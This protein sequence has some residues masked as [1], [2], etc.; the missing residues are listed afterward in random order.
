MGVRVGAVRTGMVPVRL[1]CDDGVM[2]PR[3]VSAGSPMSRC[4]VYLLRMTCCWPHGA[5]AAT[6]SCKLTPH[7]DHQDEWGNS[8]ETLD[9]IDESNMIG[10]IRIGTAT[11][12]LV[13]LELKAHPAKDI[14][15]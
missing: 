14:C 15:C 3:G 4:Q 6:N 2:A 1:S 10:G 11:T 7:L 8:L 12:V 5:A 9:P 13:W